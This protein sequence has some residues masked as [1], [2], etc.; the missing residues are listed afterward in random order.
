MIHIQAFLMAIRAGFLKY[1]E[2]NQGSYTALSCQA[3]R[4]LFIWNSALD[5]VFH[6]S[7]PWHSW[8]SRQ[9][10]QNLNVPGGFHGISFV[11][12]MFHRNSAWLILFTSLASH[13]RS[14]T[15]FL[16]VPSQGSVTSNN[17]QLWCCQP[18]FSSATTIY[19][20]WKEYIERT[21]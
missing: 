17:L 7:W 18:D 6:L 5:V 19:F 20:N 11:L 16:S 3:L 15:R 13:E 1:L 21:F 9:V 10:L 4:S 2:S 14:S 8:V 12:N